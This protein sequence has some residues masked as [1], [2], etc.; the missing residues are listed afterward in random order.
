MVIYHGGTMCRSPSRTPSP[1]M[2]KHL[3]PGG[4][5]SVDIILTSFIHIKLMPGYCFKWEHYRGSSY[6]SSHRLRER[7]SGEP[8]DCPAYTKLTMESIQKATGNR[9][10][11]E[12]KKKM[13]T[14]LGSI[15]PS[16]R[17]SVHAVWDPTCLGNLGNRL[18]HSAEAPRDDSTLLT[19]YTGSFHSSDTLRHPSALHSPGPQLCPYTVFHR[20]PHSVSRECTL[21]APVLCGPIAQRD[22]VSS[23]ELSGILSVYLRY[24]TEKTSVRVR[25]K[26]LSNLTVRRGFAPP[27]CGGRPAHPLLT[28]QSPAKSPQSSLQKAGRSLSGW[29]AD[30]GLLFQGVLHTRNTRE[31]PTLINSAFPSHS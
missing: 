21:P 30:A 2:T 11:L 26:L 24:I 6:M 28:P 4:P 3:F 25:S 9:I 23:P 22:T 29:E 5:L 12:G 13:L 18:Q 20:W 27:G 17:G 19:C 10:T 15:K 1:T 7:R 16:L 31:V 14:N 8:V